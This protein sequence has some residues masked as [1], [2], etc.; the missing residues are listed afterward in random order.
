MR[1]L[2]LSAAVLLW[3]GVACD[4]GDDVEFPDSGP[5]ATATECLMPPLDVLQPGAIPPNPT[6]LPPAPGCAMGSY[7]AIIVLGCPSTEDGAPSQC[8]RM[9][10]ELALEFAAAGYADSF[11]VTGAAVANAHVEADALAGLLIEGGV[12]DENIVREPRAEHTDEKD[13]KSVV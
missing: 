10:V 12:A 1:W 7:D 6:N 9:R 2:I 3:T 8:Q 4:S 11:I 13:R 5:N